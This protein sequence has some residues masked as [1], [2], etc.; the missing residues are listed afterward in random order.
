MLLG[1]LSNRWNV[2]L[3]AGALAP[4]ALQAKVIF[5]N[6]SGT[7]PTGS[8]VITGNVQDPP[9][10]AEAAEAF[11]PSGNFSMR[12][13]EVVSVGN[14][15]YFDLF[16][17]SDNS[18]EPGSEIE[19]LGS[20]LGSAL[21]I[22]NL[23]TANS[24][25][26]IQLTDGTQYWLVM[27]A[28]DPFTDGGWGTGGSSLVP[29]ASSIDDGSTWTIASYDAQFQIDGT[30]LTATPEPS[31]LPL[32]SAAVLGLLIAARRAVKRRAVKQRA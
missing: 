25:T 31:T 6:L 8:L 26:P 13:V 28:F 19:E 4:L 11:T 12:G 30:P 22:D 17:Y 7:L 1:F 10:G 16:L 20:G 14:E 15:P 9:D 18:G 29:G 24:F 3:L 27:T 32:T 23:V 5:S 2:V 21:S